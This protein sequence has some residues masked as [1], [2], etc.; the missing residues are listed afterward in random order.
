GHAAHLGGALVGMLIALA[1]DPSAMIRNYIPILVVILPTLGFLYFLVTRPHFLM[2][3]N[4][5]GSDR[6]FYSVDHKYNLNKAEREKDL[7]RILDKIKQ[8]GMKSLTSKE[9]A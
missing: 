9:K 7:D 1:M 6:H 3:D 8:K 2:I 4:Y 5:R